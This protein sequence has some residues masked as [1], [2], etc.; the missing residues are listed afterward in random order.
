MG[1]TGCVHIGLTPAGGARVFNK[2]SLKVRFP[3]YVATAM[4]LVLVVVA[5][6][7][8]R[9][10]RTA[11]VTAVHERLQRVTGQL[12]ELTTRAQAPRAAEVRALGGDPVIV[13]MLTDPM[14]DQ[15]AVRERLREELDGLEATGIEIRDQSGLR[16]VAA[17]N[18]AA[19][20]MDHSVDL[21]AG[22]GI[23]ALLSANGLVV[24]AIAAPIRSSDETVGSLYVWREAARLDEEGRRVLGDLIGVDA[25]I[26]LGSLG[27]AW[28]D[29]SSITPPPPLGLA[30]G[31]AIA[32]NEL[33]TYRRGTN[34]KVF[35]TVVPLPGTAWYLVVE[36]PADEALAGARTL[37]KRL[38][39]ILPVGL[40][41]VALVAFGVGKTVTRSL[42]ETAAGAEAIAA[43]EKGYRVPVRHDDELGRLARSFNAMA[44]QIEDSQ[45]ALRDLNASLRIMLDG[46]PLPIIV[47]DQAHRVRMWNQACETTFGWS[48]ANVVGRPSPLRDL[49]GDEIVLASGPEG[50][51][52]REYRTLRE[53]GQ[54]ID[55]FIASAPT[56]SPHGQVDGEILVCEDITARKRAEAQLER[57]AERLS[58]S[59]EELE[60]FAYVASH[61]L[62]E[63]LRMV[64]SFT[65]LLAERYSGQLD[66]EAVK[67]INF[68]V[69][70]A[71]RMEGL[72]RALL[73]YARVDA[74]SEEAVEVS[75]EGLVGD[76]LQLLS[77]AIAE[78]GAV[79]THDPLPIVAGDPD[80]LLRL[81]QNLIGNGIKFCR[82]REPRVHISVVQRGDDAVFCVRD[83]GIGI[84]EDYFERIF[85]VFRRLHGLDE[86]G[87]TGIGLAICKKIV[88]RHG[89][90][91]W[92]ESIPG[93]GS[94]FYFSIPGRLA[95][96]A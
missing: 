20:P 16:V 63:P 6:G 43:G 71:N 70:G 30:P 92:L 91:I 41:L 42:S 31:E 15:S 68:A 34:G 24:Y 86:F 64:R 66:D 57:Y 76:V 81:L 75:M 7:A 69:D 18:A 3:L 48:A 80:Q 84:E 22:S 50:V 19:M 25:N 74:P 61:D 13:Q 58:R 45:E 94:R 44:Q 12:A 77:P 79:I 82:D 90:R 72:I 9:E 8:Y 60:N 27:G 35:A 52:G 29:L 28:S 67:Y 38:L 21:E 11:Q 83:N 59:N 93:E 55:V 40:L 2:M 39:L 53:D 47:L 88:E 17:G 26:L 96:V 95:R 14:A 32:P 37:L 78:T 10:V 89:G 62:R 5:L 1:E 33:L 46:A 87:G 36:L 65:G 23:G 73:E 54:I 51:S 4:T 85:Q 49:G 56:Y